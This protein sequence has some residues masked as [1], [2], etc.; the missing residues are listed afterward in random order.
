MKFKPV[1]GLVLIVLA[2]LPT[3]AA[4]QLNWQVV[5]GTWGGSVE[6]AYDLN[7]H[8][9]DSS[10]GPTESTGQQLRESVRL[11]NSNFYAVD[12][13]FVVGNVGVQL[14]LNQGKS[15]GTSGSTAD[16]G[17]VLGYDFNATVL[18]DKPYVANFFA[19]KNQTISNQA[20]GGTVNGVREAKGMKLELHEDSV[21]KDKGFPWFRA[22]LSVQ[23]D[24]GQSTTTFFDRVTYQTEH[25]RTLNFIAQKGFTTA[26]LYARYFVLNDTASAGLNYSLDFGPGLNRSFNSTLD[27]VKHHGA[28]ESQSLSLSE[29]LSMTHFKNLASNYAYSF[30]S[31]QSEGKVSREQNASASVQHVLYTNLT[32]KADVIGRHLVLPEGSVNSGG[33]HFNQS[34][35]HSLPA[36]GLLNLNWSNSYDLTSND[37]E[38]GFIKV[39]SEKHLAPAVFGGGNGFYLD[40][41][42]AVASSV[43]I[44]NLTTGYLVPATEYSVVTI[45]D[46][47][48]IEPVFRFPTDPRNPIEPNDVLDVS[49]EYKLDPKLK[50]AMRGAGF[51][52]AVDYGWVSPF[53]Q[54][55]QTAG[56]LLKGQGLLVNSVRTDN[57]GVTFKYKLRDMPTSLTLTR[58]HKSDT[59]LSG[60]ATLASST[61]TQTIIY[62][63]D[64]IQ[65][66][67]AQANA[68]VLQRKSV[69]T[70]YLEQVRETQTEF[71]V[72]GLWHEFTGVAKA[73]FNDYRSNLLA[74]SRKGLTSTLNW[75]VDYSLSVVASLNT[76]SI[77]YTTSKVSDSTRAARAAANWRNDE[78]WE[79]EAFAELRFHDDGRDNPETIIQLGGRSKVVFGKLSL[80]GGASYDRWVRGST[81]SNGLRFN[82][83][84]LRSF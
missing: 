26:D 72:N 35:Q 20:F 32:T 59:P 80:T 76:T 82:V 30:T 36:K 23:Q 10:T 56:T 48:H 9:G 47:V 37:L 7:L 11:S 42:N 83:S 70:A 41:V 52:A 57:A 24:Q 43:S 67:D 15:N 40:R 78:G 18:K 27:Y 53:Y 63:L 73:T 68:S 31:Q 2:G 55:N 84:A 75:Q 58:G 60:D 51:G 71:E 14:N 21:L 4:S 17:R 19:N 65:H 62:R 28:V 50:Y 3:L 74:Y 49:Y 6:T 22:E 61:N 1:S 79:H 38:V 39:L 66:G 69:E 33:V 16:S 13:R 34:Y 54:H 44:T 46:K 5:P 64:G 8:S 81:R 45:A 25:N 29:S 77:L 12:P